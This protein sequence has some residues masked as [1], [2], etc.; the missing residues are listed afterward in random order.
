MGIETGFFTME[1]VRQ[2]TALNLVQGKQLALQQLDAFQATHP[3]VHAT[4]LA[5]AR[6]AIDRATTVN[7]LALTLA[8]FVLAHPSENLKVLR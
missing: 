3:G 6:T 2:V 7:R 4:N 8:N 5:K 1:T